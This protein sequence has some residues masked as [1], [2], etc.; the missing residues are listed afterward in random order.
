MVTNRCESEILKQGG[1]GIGDGRTLCAHGESEVLVSKGESNAW[2]VN[3]VA[4]SGERKN[5]VDGVRED[6]YNM[7]EELKDQ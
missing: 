2:R 5:G 4:N 6:Y 1:I 3:K 7:T